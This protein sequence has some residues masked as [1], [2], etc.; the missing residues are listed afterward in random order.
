M[1]CFIGDFAKTVCANVVN[2]V[3]KRGGSLVKSGHLQDTNSSGE[4][5]HFF[6]FIFCRRAGTPATGLK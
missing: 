2:S 6:E 5:A 4:N 3:Q 1:W